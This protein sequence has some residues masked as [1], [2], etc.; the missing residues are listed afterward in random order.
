MSF[1]SSTEVSI[2]ALIKLCLYHFFGDHIK[3]NFNSM[4]G[5]Q[6][7]K[8]ALD[9]SGDCEEKTKG[10]YIDIPIVL[11]DRLIC[12][13]VDENQHRYYQVA[14]E[15]ARYDT[16]AYGATSLE[17]VPTLENPF[18]TQGRA[19]IVIRL[20]PHDITDSMV[21]PF[22]ERVRVFIQMFR[23]LMTQPLSENDRIGATV[24]YLFYGEGNVHQEAAQH[25]EMTIR[26]MPYVNDPAD[27]PL[28]EDIAAFKLEDL[29][30]RDV[31]AA[32]QEIL[33]QKQIELSSGKRQC[34]AMNH[35][36]NPALKQRCSAATKKGQNLC[37]RHFDQ[38]ANGK[39]LILADDQ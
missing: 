2:E 35:A 31:E 33:V 26:I 23:N 20:N 8:D 4:I 7:C 25:A 39:V 21:V 10:A 19:T 5:G 13:E 36:N 24:H 12:G 32:A 14:C 22:I 37:G 34:A 11:P 27:V 1:K 17:L 6:S 15:L 18:P 30:Q 3:S 28:D 29:V 38:Q 16:L 9:G